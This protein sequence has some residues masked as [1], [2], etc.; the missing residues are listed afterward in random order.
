[1]GCEEGSYRVQV[2]LMF[3]AGNHFDSNSG[4]ALGQSLSALTALQILNLSCE[5]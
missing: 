2:T 3:A 1:V 5:T 4:A